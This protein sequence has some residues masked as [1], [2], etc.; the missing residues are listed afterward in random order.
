MEKN[1]IKILSDNKLFAWNFTLGGAN[2]GD[3]NFCIQYAGK[4]C[5]FCKE[6]F[7]KLSYSG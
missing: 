7:G 3:N 6:K 2:Y 4:P 5:R 1:I